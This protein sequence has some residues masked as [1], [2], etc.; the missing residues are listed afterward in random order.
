MDAN[1]SETF[2]ED[3]K[4]QKVQF[5]PKPISPYKAKVKA[6]TGVQGN[7]AQGSAVEGM[8]DVSIEDWWAISL[9]K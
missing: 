4:V 3:F 8:L 9:V 1:L 2:T 5:A 7:R 6:P